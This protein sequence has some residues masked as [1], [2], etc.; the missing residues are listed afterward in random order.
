[1][2]DTYEIPSCP[3]TLMCSTCKGTGKLGGSAYLTET[4]AECKGSGMTQRKGED[5]AER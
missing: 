2:P 4:C 1:M 3:A 5:D